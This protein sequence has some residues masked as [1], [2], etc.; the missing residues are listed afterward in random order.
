MM[1]SR[2]GSFMKKNYYKSIALFIAMITFFA[3]YQ[4]VAAGK[5]VSSIDPINMLPFLGIAVL[6]DPSHM[7]PYKWERKCLKRCCAY[8]VT[9]LVILANWFVEPLIYKHYDSVYVGLSF[10]AGD[11]VYSLFFAMFLKKY[12]FNEEDKPESNI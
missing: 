3:Y 11:I 2:K 10:L 12:C 7:W 6:S 5:D 1:I 9:I 8:W 4:I